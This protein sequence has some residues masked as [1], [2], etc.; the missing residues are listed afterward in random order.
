MDHRKI[1]SPLYL[2]LVSTSDHLPSSVCAHFTKWCQAVWAAP[3]S[4]SFLLMSVISV[5]SLSLLQHGGLS[6]VTIGN[7]PVMSSYQVKNKRQYCSQF[8][9][10]WFFFYGWAKCL[11]QSCHLL[12]LLL[13]MI[14]KERQCS[15]IKRKTE[16]EES[17]IKSAVLLVYSTPLWYQQL[18]DIADTKD[19]VFPV[20]D[21]FHALKGI[22]NSVSLPALCWCVSV[23]VYCWTFSRLRFV[24][25]AW[26]E[27]VEFMLIHI[28]TL[29]HKAAVHLK[30]FSLF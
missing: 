1:W 23:C 24:V 9:L 5:V 17:S 12:C 7:H 20:K 11:P 21:G 19:Q 14:W 10:Q 3:E 4:Q 25:D 13:P 29:G 6:L 16:K 8:V 2:L 22:V 15:V 28:Q 18:A 27:K 26:D 30:V